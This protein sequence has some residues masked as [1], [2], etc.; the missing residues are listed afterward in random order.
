MPGRDR[1]A[2]PSMRSDACGDGMALTQIERQYDS[3]EFRLQDEVRVG[4]WIDGRNAIF[5]GTVIGVQDMEL[6][7]GLADVDERLA[8]LGPGHR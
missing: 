7:I 2:V 6:W 3:D 8:A 1:A 4:T 5:R